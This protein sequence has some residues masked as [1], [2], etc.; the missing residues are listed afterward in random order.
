MNQ[1][2]RATLER[3]LADDF[4]QTHAVGRTDN[5]DCRLRSLAV[6]Q[7]RGKG[8]APR[9]IAA[10]AIRAVSCRTLVVTV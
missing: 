4:T 10:E 8:G 2:D 1:K 3:L 7:H 9:H 6:R 5:R